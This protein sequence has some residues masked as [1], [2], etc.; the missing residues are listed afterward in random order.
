VV[1]FLINSSKN[2]ASLMKY[3]RVGWIRWEYENITDKS[4]ALFDDHLDFLGGESLLKLV[5]RGYM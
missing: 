3:Q 1:P 2:M 4:N 5:F